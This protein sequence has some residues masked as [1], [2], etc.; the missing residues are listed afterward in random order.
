MLASKQTS[1]P[2][3]LQL[4]NCMPSILSP[5]SRL[6]SLQSR[7]QDQVAG[8]L[9]DLASQPA[10][11]ADQCVP[12]AVGDR[13]VVI[14]AVNVQEIKTVLIE[15]GADHVGKNRLPRLPDLL[16]R[17]SI[18]HQYRGMYLLWKVDYIRRDCTRGH[19]GRLLH[20]CE[21]RCEG[22]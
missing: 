8:L 3:L 10:R 15:R 6:S 16:V 5:L 12:C 18:A 2:H 19:A 11:R 7:L 14:A 13:H 1:L 9:S 4:C 17:V 22:R 21:W 20:G